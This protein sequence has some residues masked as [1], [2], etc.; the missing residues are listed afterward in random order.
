[1]CLIQHGTVNTHF[2]SM[3][4]LEFQEIDSKKYAHEHFR[5]FITV[6]VSKPFKV[7]GTWFL[8]KNSFANMKNLVSAAYQEC[9]CYAKVLPYFVHFCLVTYKLWS[10]DTHQLGV[11]RCQTRVAALVSKTD[12]TPMIK[13]SYTIF[14]NYYRCRRVCIVFGV[15]VSVYTS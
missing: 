14:S 4:I 15:H 11:S 5:S 1:L 6:N 7:L 3:I 13:L 2:I 10:T 12:T 8:N 9:Y